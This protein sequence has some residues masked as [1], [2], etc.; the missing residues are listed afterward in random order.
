MEATASNVASHNPQLARWDGKDIV[1]IATDELLGC[2]VAGG[3]LQARTFGQPA[4]K[5]A[6]LQECGRYSLHG[7]LPSLDRPGEP[8]GNHLQEFG[9][10]IVE[11]GGMKPADVE[12]TDQVVVG[13]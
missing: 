6:V 3:E 12:H 13:H 7:Q 4:R 10:G 11:R 5:Q 1:P 9:I 8:F 2:E